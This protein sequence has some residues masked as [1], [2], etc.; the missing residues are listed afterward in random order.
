MTIRLRPHHLLCMLTFAGKGY[1]PA[2]VANFEQVASRIA[3]GDEAI[4]I[5]DGPDDICSPRLAESTCH[6]HNSSVILRDRHAT[7]AISDLL[8]HQIRPGTNLLPHQNLLLILREAFVTG[9]IRKACT[10]CQ[11]KPTC[12]SIAKQGFIETRL[13]A[14]PQTKADHGSHG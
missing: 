10:G 5:V 8:S 2:F 14:M 4:Q 7:E 13:G 1:T 12:D 9:A 6:C 11:W 3:R